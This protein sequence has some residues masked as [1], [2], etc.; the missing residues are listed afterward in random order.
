MSFLTSLRRTV[1]SALAGAAVV[2]FF[3]PTE[4]ISGYAGIDIKQNTEV[5][6]TSDG[7][8]GHYNKHNNTIT[9][10]VDNYMEQGVARSTVLR[11]EIIHRIQCNIGTKEVLPKSWLRLIVA[12]TFTADEV[13]EVVLQYSEEEHHGEYEARIF[14]DLP[15]GIVS[16]LLFY[17]NIYRT[18]RKSIT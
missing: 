1:I 12:Q 5:C 17:T 14:Q 3:V 18:I 2:P 7:Y 15:E 8:L 9:V 11:H 13:L 16:G 6:N 4:A 10:C